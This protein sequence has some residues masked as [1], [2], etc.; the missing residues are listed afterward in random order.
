MD[1][2]THDA[3]VD[4]EYNAPII[5]QQGEIGGKLR[6]K[7]KRLDTEQ[8]YSSIDENEA[9]TQAQQQQRKLL[10]FRLKII[11]ASDIP[12]NL[13]HQVFCKYRF[14]TDDKPTL[15][16]PSSDTS[17]SKTL[18]KFNH[19]NEFEI[20]TSEDFFDYCVDSALSI[21]VLSHRF[22]NLSPQE[23]LSNL[24]NNNKAILNQKSVLEEISRLTQVAKYQSLV[25]SWSEVSKSFELN[26]KILELNTEGN[27]TPV[28]V[29]HNVLNRTGGVYQLRQGQSR[30]ISVS[31]KQTKKDSVM[32]YN[33]LLFNLEPHKIDTISVG[34]VLGKDLG[35][36]QPLD[37]YQESDLNKLK[38]K[39]RQIL[40]DRK[41][42]LYSQLKLL[43]EEQNKSEEENERYE[44]LCKQLV[45]L[46]EEQ[47]AIDAPADNSGLPGSTIEWR[48]AEN[49][50]EH[51]PIIFLNLS[52]ETSRSDSDAELNDTNHTSN[53]SDESE[54]SSRYSSNGKKSLKKVAKKVCGNFSSRAFF[55]S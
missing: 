14:W 43:S 22:H 10:K 20:E 7:L 12:F 39:C 25:D 47:A 26:V 30:Q 2:L 27:W 41:L 5:N 44:S 16:K 49:M 36:T 15:V 46:G 23:Q 55:F 3:P 11:E 53:D 52:D 54:D 6:V 48:P 45:D 35:L 50:E 21:E 9:T 34:C 38:E 31:L 37:S 1:V 42:Y 33:G 17:G 13:S 29:K 32:W 28:D 8:F 51:V 24:L 4:F 18:V 40:E 19:H